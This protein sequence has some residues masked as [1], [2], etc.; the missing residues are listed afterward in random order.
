MSA[1]S[2][3]EEVINDLIRRETIRAKV[4][5]Q[6]ASGHFKNAA[7]L[8]AAAAKAYDPDGGN[9]PDK[10]DRLSQQ[11][12]KESDAGDKARDKALAEE[13]RIKGKQECL[14][15]IRKKWRAGKSIPSPR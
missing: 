15:G 1:L 9:S 2:E 7:R 13:A 11:A 10:G 14:D 6:I 4:H 5:R 3:I 12:Q 8:F